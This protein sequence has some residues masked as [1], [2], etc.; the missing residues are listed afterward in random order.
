MSPRLKRVDANVFGKEQLVLTVMIKYA[1]GRNVHA[2]VLEL[3]GD[4][5]CKRRQGRVP[6]SHNKWMKLYSSQTVKQLQKVRSVKDF[7]LFVT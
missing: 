2:Q 6:R 1:K 7:I 4:S 3:Q 5:A